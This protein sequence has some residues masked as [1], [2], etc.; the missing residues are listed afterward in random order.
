MTLTEF[1]TLAI[2]LVSVIIAVT[3]LI[4]TRG[5]AAEQLKLEAITAKL[6]ERQLSQ[7]EEEAHDRTQ[8]KLHVDLTKLG[9]NWKFLIAN[10]GEGSAFNLRLELIDCADSPLS[11]SEVS[12]KFPYP[13]LK[14]QSRIKLIAGIHMQSPRTYQVRLTWEDSRDVEHVEDFHVAL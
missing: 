6:A 12:E 8:A 13:E 11:Q 2:S 4:R 7:I 14:T 9:K 3:S 5:I 1:L 10:R